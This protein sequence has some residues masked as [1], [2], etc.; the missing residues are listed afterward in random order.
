VVLVRAK[1][2]LGIA[3]KNATLDDR[4]TMLGHLLGGRVPAVSAVGW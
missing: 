1:R 3:V 4:W 2:A